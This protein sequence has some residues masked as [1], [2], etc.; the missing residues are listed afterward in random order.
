MSLNEELTAIE[1]AVDECETEIAS[2]R[3]NVDTLLNRM[4]EIKGLTD[5]NMAITKTGEIIGILKGYS[6]K[7]NIERL[8]MLK[9]QHPNDERVGNLGRRAAKCFL[10]VNEIFFLISF[11]SPN[12]KSSQQY[13]E[14]MTVLNRAVANLVS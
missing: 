7:L 9:M 4:R 1:T 13:Q 11:D 3:I 10:T 2:G 12:A 8:W 6:N 14:T 5:M